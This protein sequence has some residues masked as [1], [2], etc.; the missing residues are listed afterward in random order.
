MISQAADTPLSELT[1]LPTSRARSWNEGMKL[2]QYPARSIVLSA[3]RQADT[4]TNHP[5]S[6]VWLVE[7]VGHHELG[8]SR[9]HGL[10]G[11]SDASLVND[12]G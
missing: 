5:R 11:C 7:A 1:W 3:D 2:S 10:C 4:E 6:I 8:Y 9:S 12:A